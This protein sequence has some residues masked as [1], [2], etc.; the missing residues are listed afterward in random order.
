MERGEAKIL[1]QSQSVR[2]TIYE[3]A[4]TF[5]KESNLPVLWNLTLNSLQNYRFPSIRGITIN[6][7]I[8]GSVPH[9]W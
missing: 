4:N 7:E 9:L 1:F 8:C 6:D 2:W 5:I 3:G